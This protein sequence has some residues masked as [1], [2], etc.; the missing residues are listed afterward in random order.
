MSTLYRASLNLNLSY[1]LK[2]KKI[3]KSGNLTMADV[4]RIEFDE[5]LKLLLNFSRCGDLKVTGLAI[6][7]SKNSPQ[8]KI[9]QEIVKK[10]IEYLLRR[11]ALLRAH[12]EFVENKTFFSIS[13]D[14]KWSEVVIGEDLVFGELTSRS[15]LNAELEKI[16]DKRINYDVESKLWRVGLFSFPNDENSAVSYALALFL[17][18]YMTD[19]LNITSLSLELTNIVNS[20]V[21]GTECV[22]MREQMP[23]VDTEFNLITKQNLVGPKQLEKIQE[24]QS[25]SILKIVLTYI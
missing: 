4:K 5:Y 10:S 22:E 16:I 3:K 1:I 13:Q 15:Q 2:I 21:S 25:K 9:N 12:L 8:F 11:H 18:V 24:I 14:Q 7:E 20:I 19:A 23:L 17:P 6:L